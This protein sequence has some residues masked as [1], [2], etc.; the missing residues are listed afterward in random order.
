MVTGTTFKISPTAMITPKQF[1]LIRKLATERDWSDAP[2]LRSM[3]IKMVVRAED[4]TRCSVR[5]LDASAAIDYLLSPLAPKIQGVAAQ[6][7]GVQ[8]TTGAPPKSTPM[9]WFEVKTVLT[10]LPLSKY[11]VEHESGVVQFFEVV[12]R[13]NGARFLNKLQGAPGDWH[14]VWLNPEQQVT[15]GKIIAE[16][17]TR[18]ATAYCEKFT[19]CSA[20]DSPLSVAASIAAAMGPVCRK[21]FQW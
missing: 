7:T 9:N 14:R 18:Y 16:D 13:K 15:I 11:A 21:K 4:W 10:P 5:R 1:D 3:T 8:G 19:R 2:T 20:C 12:E 17:P 6:D